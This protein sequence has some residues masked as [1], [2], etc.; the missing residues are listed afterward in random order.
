M[1]LA[2]SPSPAERF[3]TEHL[4]SRKS[5][6]LRAVAVVSLLLFVS[7]GLSSAVIRQQLDLRVYL[8]GSEHLTDGLLYTAR[9]RV[10][11]HLPF[12]Y[13]AF[14]ALFFWPLQ[15]LPWMTAKIVWS[16]LTIAATF[17]IIVR[18]LTLAAPR[19]SRSAIWWTSALVSGPVFA[20]EPIRLNFH[21]GQVNLVLA[22]LILYDLT[23]DVIVAGRRL[24]RGVLIGLAAA[25]KLTPGIFILY[26]L[27]TKRFRAA[28]SAIASFVSLTAVAFAIQ[29][30]ASWKFW[31]KDAFD[32][33]RVGGIAYNSNQ[34]LRGVLYRIGHAA[35][36]PHLLMGICLIVVVFGMVSASWL[37]RRGHVLLGVLQT[38]ITGILVSPISWSH[39]LVWVIPLLLWLVLDDHRPSLGWAAA[40][41]G[42]VVLW[43]GVIWIP[44]SVGPNTTHENLKQLLQ[45][46]SY[47]LLLIAFFVSIPLILLR[48]Q[49]N[50]S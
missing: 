33:R 31:T 8:M 42:A 28:F 29:P 34:S 16:L 36:N 3:L 20:I 44:S 50:N 2:S 47:A 10:V 25:I 7:L 9:L 22:C 13:P 23:G 27:C 24:P 48:R 14:A 39:H 12:T 4:G 40:V 5:R 11:P 45:S 37:Y 15:L 43:W 6:A 26:L 32:A 17:A 35:P 49:R 46:C 38:A 21:F 18:S 1:K 30:S 19:L 41:F